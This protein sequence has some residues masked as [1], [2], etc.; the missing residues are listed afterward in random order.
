MMKTN[1]KRKNSAVKKLI[2]AAG[3]L[4][5]SASML[6]T[7]TYA[8][9]TMSREVSV[10]GMTMKTQIGANLLIASSNA[11]GAY[12]SKQL[13][14]SR[15][16][17][18]E[19]VSTINATNESF[20]YTVN[21]DALGDA[22]VDSYTNYSETVAAQITALSNTYA[23]K[24][25]YDK[26]FNSTYDVVDSNTTATAGTYAPA[27]G[28]VDY[29]FYL[30]ATGADTYDTLNMTKCELVYKNG[31][32]NQVI[33]VGDSKTGD[34]AWR[35]AIFATDITA[36]GGKGDDAEINEVA[37]SAID[38]AAS[39]NTP[40]S[41]LKLDGATN[42]TSGKAVNS[43]TTLDTVVSADQAVTLINNLT[44]GAEKYYKVTA[45][46][47]L[48]GEDNTCTNTTYATL[49]SNWSLNLKF[50]L[51]ADGTNAVTKIGS[52]GD[53]TDLSPVI[54]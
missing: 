50:E 22:K 28:Y 30:K 29:V 46:V 43:G 2:P 4:A 16:A 40:I 36:Q 15:S 7:S 44:A 6:A 1:A 39:G 17:L 33:G 5:L 19:P 20:Y 21:A 41:I 48:E 23:N 49:D 34:Q 13:S 31:G 32:S 25:A 18:L 9:F 26:N 3:M 54:N 11:S 12:G 42:F 24:S 45:R 27:Y 14:Q 37:V 51:E 52:A 10:V 38:P 35:V 47:W 53:W 8:W